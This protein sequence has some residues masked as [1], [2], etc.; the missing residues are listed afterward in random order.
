MIS[1]SWGRAL[2]YV[3]DFYFF[4]DHAFNNLLEAVAAAFDL[5]TTLIRGTLDEGGGVIAAGDDSDLTHFEISPL[6]RPLSAAFLG[7]AGSRRAGNPSIF[8]VGTGIE[9][10]E[11]G[12]EGEEA[13]TAYRRR[14]RDSLVITDLVYQDKIAPVVT[15]EMT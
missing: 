2:D 8:G 15:E 3:S 1:T 9:E 13:E 14:I 10:S 4:L 6:A 11:N 5:A 7:T 12:E